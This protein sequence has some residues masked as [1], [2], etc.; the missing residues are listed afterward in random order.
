M[1]KV[2]VTGATG[3]L[4]S[5]L[6]RRLVRSGIEVRI[7]RR[8]TSRLHALE[9]VA[10]SVEHAIGDLHDES[11]LRDAMTGIDQVYHAAAYVSFGG[12]SDREALMRTNVDGTAAVVNAALEAGVR[13]LVH[14]SSM[15]AFGRPEHTDSVLDERSQWHRSRANTV[16]ARSK[17]LSELQVQRGVAEG[18]DGVIVNPALIFGIG[19]AGMNTRQLVDRVRKERLPAIPRGGTNVVDVLDVVGGMVRAMERGR[20]GERYFLGSENLSWRRIIET[21][22]FAFGVEP[23]RRTISPTLAMLLAY[24]AEAVATLT[25]S[26]PV[27]TR[28]HARSGSRFYHYSNRKAV[29]ELGCTFRP[30]E[31]TAERLSSRLDEDASPDA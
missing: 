22:S 7:L 31:A 15:A 8:E 25:G 19:R 28:E 18:L 30:F 2:L 13:R 29:E 26:R 5:A 23:P 3:L 21:L 14:T 17:Y 27:I 24:A 11:S 9:D 10:R 4:G 1:P 20:T 6:T 12:R 16:Y